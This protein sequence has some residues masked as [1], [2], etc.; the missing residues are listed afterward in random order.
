MNQQVAYPYGRRAKRGLTV[1]PD[2]HTKFATILVGINTIDCPEHIECWTLA[3]M[4]YK[5]HLPISLVN[6]NPRQ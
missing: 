5:N 6:N 2:V 4:D 3:V 1:C